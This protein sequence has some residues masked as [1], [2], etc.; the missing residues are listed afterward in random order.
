MTITDPDSLPRRLTV[1]VLTLAV[2]ASAL[3]ALLTKPWAAE[4]TRLTAD[5][6]EASQGLTTT[7]PVKIRGMQVGQVEEIALLPDGR[8]RLTLRI[9]EGVRVPTS[10]RASLEPES[11]FGPKFINL[12]PGAGE[13]DGP[14]LAGGA[15]IA[16]TE[17]SGDLNDLLSDANRTLAAIDPR[18]VSIIVGTLAQGLGGQGDQLRGLIDD[19]ATLVAIGHRHRERARTFTADLARLTEVRGVG[20]AVAGIAGDTDAV[21]D[22]AASGEGRLRN[23]A[24]GGAQLAGTLADGLNRHGG[25]LRESFRSA[26]RATALVYAQ[27]GVAGPAIRQMTDLLPLYRTVGWPPAPNGKHMLAVKVMLPSDPCE[28]LLGLC[29]AG[30]G[31]APFPATGGR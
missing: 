9:E 10:V 3:Y 15:H 20:S 21:V 31:P 14:F 6:D 30:T 24:G 13:K 2:A 27:L 16:A 12:L 18:D 7:S 23:L 1:S 4:G 19:T 29:P 8:A 5:F 25:Q 28:L 26:E 17:E 11:V 22:T